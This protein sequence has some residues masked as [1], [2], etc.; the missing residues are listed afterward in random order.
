M[1]RKSVKKNL[2]EAVEK[3]C[4]EFCEENKKLYSERDYYQARRMY[5]KYKFGNYHPKTIRDVKKRG[6]IE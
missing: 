4:Q 1:T 2:C 5:L 6:R 3:L